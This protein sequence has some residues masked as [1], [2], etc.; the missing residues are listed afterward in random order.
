MNTTPNFSF[1][2]FVAVCVLLMVML[3]S[4]GGGT[5]GSSSTVGVRTLTIKGN[6]LEENGKPI[7][8]SVVH[9][10]GGADTTLTDAAGNFNLA[11]TTSPSFVLNIDIG[12]STVKVPV[13]DVEDAASVVTINTNVDAGRNL[14][15]SEFV[16]GKVAVGSDCAAFATVS[17]STV[18]IS[19]PN[20]NAT[21]ELDYVFHGTA[22]SL[23]QTSLRFDRLSCTNLSASLFG[24]QIDGDRLRIFQG[25]V[26]KQS[27]QSCSAKVTAELPGL[28][29]PP[30]FTI[31]INP[32]ST[33]TSSLR[34]T[35]RGTLVAKRILGAGKSCTRFTESSIPV[36][37]RVDGNT[38]SADL[39][40]ENLRLTGN[41]NPNGDNTSQ[42]YVLSSTLTQSSAVSINP[43]NQLGG[44]SATFS[45]FYT[46]DEGG[47]SCTRFFQGSLN[48]S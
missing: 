41:F 40:S 27:S 45:L 42:Q 7:P 3:S 37:Y 30:T 6:V 14:L 15:S 36:T 25:L 43:E 19:P 48:K 22:S 11:T 26:I 31:I 13:E 2:I 33:P 21:C 47:K 5:A 4:C 35:Y 24:S 23:S 1:R 32:S 38:L 46:S 16:D 34:A 44:K 28:S 9:I 18:R 12:T 17:G 29:T 10:E 20:K 8:D 39:S